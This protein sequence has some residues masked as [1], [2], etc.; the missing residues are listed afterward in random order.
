MTAPD[1]PTATLNRWDRT[2]MIASAACAVHCTLLPL[3]AAAAPILGL[4]ALLDE[5]VEW[6]L[7]GATAVVGLIGH[8]RAYWRDHRHV[9]PGLIFAIGLSLVLSGRLLVRSP[10]LE[11]IALGLGGTLAA[12]SHYA[13]LRLCRCCVECAGDES[14]ESPR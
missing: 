8:G 4:S 9:A 5:R 10:W 7:V 1:G 2:G 11:P 12:A 6:T 13:N 3:V 14:P